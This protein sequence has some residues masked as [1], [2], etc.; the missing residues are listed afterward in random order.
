L[1]SLKKYY[2][3]KHWIKFRKVL[4]DDIN[5][6]CE[7]CNRKKWGIYK[8]NTKKHKV[9]DKKR[10][11]ILSVHHKNYNCLNNETK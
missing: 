5:A 9:G 8:R 1:E 7:I 3:S 2:K 6:E 10:L 4:L 11:L